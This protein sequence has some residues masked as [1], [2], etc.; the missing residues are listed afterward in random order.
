MF[1]VYVFYTTRTHV[2]D[3]WNIVSWMLKC[4]KA[5]WSIL[6]DSLWISALF[7]HF[8]LKFNGPWSKSF[9]NT[10]SRIIRVKPWK[11]QFHLFYY[12]LCISQF[13]GRERKR[14]YRIACRN[15]PTILHCLA[16][17]LTRIYR[18]AHIQ[19]ETLARLSARFREYTVY[20][21]RNENKR[22]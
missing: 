22:F 5:A 14:K 19:S 2:L 21:N 20:E 4:Y 16:Y 13:I 3:F 11:R 7:R 17:T 10:T 12:S 9:A 15:L 8:T 6:I 1:Q 18:R